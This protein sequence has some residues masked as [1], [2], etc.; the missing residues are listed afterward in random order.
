MM[1]QDRFEDQYLDVLQNLEFAIVQAAR[2]QPELADWHVESAV[3]A[4]RKLYRAEARGNEIQDP[5]AGLDPLAQEVYALMK[6]MAELRLGRGQGFDEDGEPVEIPC[7][8]ITAQEIV[9]CLKRIRKS[10]Q[11]WTK[12]GGRKGYLNYVDEFFPGGP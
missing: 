6:G 12:W 10:I 5:S 9:D 11:R 4:L 3:N 8:P 1:R 7:E 2:E